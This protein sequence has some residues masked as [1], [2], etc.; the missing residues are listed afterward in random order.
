MTGRPVLRT[1]LVLNDEDDH[2]N[3][4]RKELQD[5][6]VV[7]DRAAT[8]PEAIGKLAARRYDLVVCDVVLCDPPGGSTPAPTGYLAVCYALARHPDSVVV[9]ASTHRRWVHPGAVLTDWT[10][11]VVADLVY[12]AAGPTEESY[13]GCPWSKLLDAEAATTSQRANAA[14]DLLR[15]PFVDGLRGTLGLDDLFEAVE[16]AA[17]DS[18]EWRR[19]LCDLRTTL[20]P[21]V[22]P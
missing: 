8:L 3:V 18:R 13:G 12:G 10:P 17:H 20:F 21:G 19:A 7:I 5:H 9:Q 14:R 16:L 4:M 1:A 6:G 11:Q 2:A 22:Q 15:L